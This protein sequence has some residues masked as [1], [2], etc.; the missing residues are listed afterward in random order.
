MCGEG[1][2]APVRLMEGN[3][4]KFRCQIHGTEEGVS[5]KDGKAVDGHP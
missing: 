5:T 2:V 4:V 3:V 1:C